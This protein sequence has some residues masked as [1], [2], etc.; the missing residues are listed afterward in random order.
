[1]SSY[2]QQLRAT[3]SATIRITLVQRRSPT[4]ARLRAMLKF[5][6]HQR[7]RQSGNRGGCRTACCRCLRAAARSEGCSNSLIR[8]AQLVLTFRA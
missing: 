3:R 7:E 6:L 8:T 1:M 2:H 5:Y 4:S